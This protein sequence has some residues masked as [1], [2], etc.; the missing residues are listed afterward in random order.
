MQ[1]EPNRQPTQHMI[2]LSGLWKYKT[3]KTEYLAGSFGM[4][5]IYIFTNTRKVKP[6]DPD[7]NL[8]IA[9]RPPRPPQS[10]TTKAKP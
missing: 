8:M 5:R 1:T 3:A 4:A 6:D 10:P 7:F 9:E 2:K